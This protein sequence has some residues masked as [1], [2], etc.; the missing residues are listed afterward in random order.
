MLGEAR[1]EDQELPPGHM[2]SADLAQ[3]KPS[4]A[5]KG[6]TFT[7]TPPPAKENEAFIEKLNKE[8][9]AEEARME[10][11]L[12]KQ[13]LGPAMTHESSGLIKVG[14][15]TEETEVEEVSTMDGHHERKELVKKGNEEIMTITSDDEARLTKDGEKFMGE[16]I[17]HH[18]G[19][20][21]SVQKTHEGNEY[22]ETIKIHTGDDASSG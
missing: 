19:H 1:E 8:M 20:V 4:V 15:I 21:D 17:N 18:H 11:G 12:V 7:Y 5:I 10:S 3:P 6:E 2:L 16:E 22:K 9:L 14:P 13:V